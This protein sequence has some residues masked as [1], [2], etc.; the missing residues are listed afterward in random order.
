M[1]RLA[2][3]ITILATLI[4]ICIPCT[5]AKTK[6]FEVQNCDINGKD[7]Q[8]IIAKIETDY[9]FRLANDKA[10]DRRD[11]NAIGYV[12]YHSDYNFKDRDNYSYTEKSVL[13]VGDKAYKKL[14]TREIEFQEGVDQITDITACMIY[15]D[16]SKK[17]WI[18][19]LADNITEP[20]PEMPDGNEKMF[21][22]SDD[23]EIQIA[24]PTIEQPYYLVLKYK[25][26]VPYIQG[27]PEGQSFYITTP[28]TNSFPAYDYQYVISI[29]SNIKHY[30]KLN[31]KSSTLIH[32][33]SITTEK[34]D[35]RTIYTLKLNKSSIL[36]ETKSN[37]DGIRPYFTFSTHESW[38]SIIKSHYNAFEHILLNGKD[39]LESKIK[40]IAAYYEKESSDLTPMDVYNY[41]GKYFHYLYY[42]TGNGGKVPNDIDVILNN[43]SGDCKDLAIVLTGLLRA[44]GYESYVVII[45]TTNMMNYDLNEP[46]DHFNHAIAGYYD[47]EKGDFHLLDATAASKLY[48]TG[49]PNSDSD[50][51]YISY[52]Y[53]E[54]NGFTVV[55][56]RSPIAS[57]ESESYYKD[58]KINVKNNKDHKN[59]EIAC[60]T[61]IHGDLCDN[62]VGSLYR[63]MSNGAT[64]NETKRALKDW[65]LKD[66]DVDSINYN[67]Q[68][69]G[70]NRLTIDVKADSGNSSI[71][72]K[73]IG[74]EEYIL[75]TLQTPDIVDTGER[76]TPYNYVDRPGYYDKTIVYNVPEGYVIRSL[77]EPFEYDSD[78]LFFHVNIVKLNNKQIEYSH[79]IWYKK[80]VIPAD[81]CKKESENMNAI[82]D[83][84]DN[85]SIVLKKAAGN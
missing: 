5:Y 78:Y 48:Y 47:K 29:P 45:R 36:N 55:K 37:L 60:Q 22:F 70:N 77:P 31:S 52:R 44:I 17:A 50:R 9:D 66:Q 38:E 83:Y 65:F 73:N 27:F 72:H 85:N 46:A 51:N 7:F 8:D 79:I 62:S 39:Q 54:K 14:A 84:T 18:A 53:S 2:K 74:E 56:G 42:H 67:I 64:V 20:Y 32:N 13:Y 28:Y 58:I 15:F 43:E 24:Y 40:N 71:K 69:L 23:K 19:K 10:T 76:K 35:N 63:N 3:R 33:F 57:T 25:K 61:T 1:K 59:P 82:K 49:I 16:Y 26:N 81:E 4:F 41:M 75:I 11:K 6:T 34:K 12:M 80:T 68:E 21:L 30:T